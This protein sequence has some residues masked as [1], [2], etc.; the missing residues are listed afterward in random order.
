MIHSAASGMS[1]RFTMTRCRPALTPVP[2]PCDSASPAVAPNDYSFIFA[3]AAVLM[4]TWKEWRTN[5][6]RSLINPPLVADGLALR[7]LRMDDG[8]VQAALDAA[9][10]CPAQASK[11]G[12]ALRATIDASVEVCASPASIGTNTSTA[13]DLPL[14]C[15]LPTGRNRTSPSSSA[16]VEAATMIWQ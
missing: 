5:P 10:S 6:H 16:T 3:R 14:S 12:Y 8:F 2:W 9:R 4:Q 13:C 7:I 1:C 11:T 15:R